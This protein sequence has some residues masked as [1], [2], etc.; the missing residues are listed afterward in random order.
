MFWRAVASDTCGDDPALAGMQE[1]V[2]TLLAQLLDRADIAPFMR[3]MAV[4]RYYLPQ[5][6]GALENAPPPPGMDLGG[7]LTS[8]AAAGAAAARGGKDGG[9]GGV[10][11]GCG[12]LGGAAPPPSSEADSNGR[13][14]AAELR[15]VA[16][17][18]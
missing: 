16:D 7:L 6:P 10:G 4:G 12:W 1:Q 2:A 15:A 13:A 14:G 5:M 17:P 11:G 9:G 8:G 18:D 3:E